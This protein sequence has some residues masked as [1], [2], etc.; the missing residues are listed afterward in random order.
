MMG[1]EPFQGDGAHGSIPPEKDS[2]LS[3]WQCGMRPVCDRESDAGSWRFGRAAL[4]E[5]HEREKTEP[6]DNQAGATE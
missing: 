5:E 4:C 6:L 3:G 2:V 1:P